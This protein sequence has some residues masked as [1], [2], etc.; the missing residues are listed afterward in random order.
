VH[1]CSSGKK[2]GLT[3]EVAGALF[4]PVEEPGRQFGTEADDG[5]GSS[6]EEKAG[7]K[8]IDGAIGTTRKQE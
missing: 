2:N 3:A 6:S 7:S 4:I 1:L 5:R 8:G